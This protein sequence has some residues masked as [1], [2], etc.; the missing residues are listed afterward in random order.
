[1]TISASDRGGGEH[2]VEVEIDEP[3]TASSSSSASGSN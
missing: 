3:L 2:S 1:M